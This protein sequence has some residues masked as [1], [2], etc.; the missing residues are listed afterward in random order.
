MR[1]GAEIKKELIELGFVRSE[2]VK[3][4]HIDLARIVREIGVGDPSGW[5]TFL[6]KTSPGPRQKTRLVEL[7]I[8]NLKLKKQLEE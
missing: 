2:G 4:G 8:E 3:E 7:F 1:T 6:K 5:S